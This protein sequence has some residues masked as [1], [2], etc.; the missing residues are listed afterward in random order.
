MIVLFGEMLQGLRGNRECKDAYFACWHEELVYTLLPDARNSRAVPGSIC[1]ASDD[2]DISIQGTGKPDDEVRVVVHRAGSTSEKETTSLPIK[3]T[4]HVRDKTGWKRVP[5]QIVPVRA[6]LFSRFRGLLETPIFSDKMVLV[7]GQGSGGSLVALELAKSGVMNF[8]LVDDDRLEVGNVVRHVAGLSHVGRYKTKVMADLIREK[9]PYA[10]VETWEE[11]VSWKNAEAV[12]DLVRKADIIV[13][14]TDERQSK[15]VINRLCVEEKKPCVFG[16]AFRRA[17][18]G[19]VLLLRPY[20]SPCYQCFLMLLPD[21]AG[22]EEISSQEQADGLAYTD[23]PVPVEPG[24]S[25]DIAPISI[26]VVK[27]VIQELLKGTETT[28]RSLDDDLKASWYLW[29]NR[30]EL[31]TQYEG[32]QPLEFNVGG[33]HILRWYGV[34]VKRHP[35]CPVCGNF[36]EWLAKQRDAE[37]LIAYD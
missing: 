29:L 34:D 6:E 8:N 33:M 5:V 37:P 31:G 1:A 10:T 13:C 32:L 21:H 36:E 11:K 25:T 27:L 19:Q 7:F 28:L 22:D 35:A 3:A 18:G 23:R 20:E 15:L 30:R 4:G 17:Y 9:N 24:L 2:E 14:A 26:M 16:G 12:R